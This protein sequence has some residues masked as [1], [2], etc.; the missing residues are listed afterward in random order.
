[1]GRRIV[2]AGSLAQKPRHGGHTW[3]FL[4]YLLGFKRLG[5][6][7]LFV[8][9]LDAGMCADASGKPCSFDRSLNAHYFR[10]VMERFDLWDQ[11]TLL[12]NR[13]EQVVGLS[14]QQMLERTKD[15]AFLLNIMGFLTDGEVLECA[16]RRV[17]L[18]IDPGFGQM[19][20]DL[21][22]HNLF[23]R[24]D[25]YVTIGEMIGRPECAIPTCELEWITT[26][27]PV[28]LDY[29]HPAAAW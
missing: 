15:A 13:G 16:P 18:D 3:V 24:H 7:V 25:A 9:Q 17:F 4:Q 8:D 23:Q 11:C 10:D 14:R 2:I 5:W 28:V 29:W 22:L 26:P 20:Q 19:W 21:G 27:Q 1:M 6:D 12:Y